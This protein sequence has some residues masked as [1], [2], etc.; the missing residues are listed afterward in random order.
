[1]RH[2]LVD[3]EWTPLHGRL[4]L[5]WGK[6]SDAPRTLANAHGETLSGAFRR[7]Q[8]AAAEHSPRQ[9]EAT[10]LLA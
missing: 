9:L 4:K 8:E 6:L 5:Q 2:D 1:M 7:R 3:I 10:V